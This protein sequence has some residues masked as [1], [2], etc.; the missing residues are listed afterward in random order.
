MYDLGDIAT[1]RISYRRTY[2]VAC[3]M[4]QLRD[5]IIIS[6]FF[7]RYDYDLT[8]RCFIL[9]GYISEWYYGGN[10]PDVGDYGYLVL[11]ISVGA[12]LQKTICNI[13]QLMT[14]KKVTSSAPTTPQQGQAAILDA[15]AETQIKE[16]AERISQLELG[17]V[18]N[19]H[20]SV[21]V[22]ALIS[23]LDKIEGG[24]I[25]KLDYLERRIETMEAV[26]SAEPTTAT[27]ES[28]AD[29]QLTDLAHKIG[30]LNNSVGAY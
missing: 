10:G 27:L 22:A 21:D 24:L 23:R 25:A 17:V 5:L 28:T 15:A 3:C 6:A 1:C 29:D 18:P 8:G 7:V 30:L 20:L 13:A 4:K 16:L 2:L 11:H 19:E 12:K 26:N 9:A 14:Q